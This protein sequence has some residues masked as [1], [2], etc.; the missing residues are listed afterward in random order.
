M[1]KS[2]DNGRITPKQEQAI[3]ALLMEPNVREAARVVKIAE[4]T[5]Y[6]WIR[7]PA[8]ARAYREA[9]SV[10]VTQAVGQLQHYSATAA[11]T[12]LRVMAEPTTPPAVRVAAASRILEFSLRGIELS[13]L[14]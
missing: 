6:T 2:S 1:H 9:R 7:K 11:R 4:R 14:A 12:L 10:A 5:L 8:F 3:L 13:E